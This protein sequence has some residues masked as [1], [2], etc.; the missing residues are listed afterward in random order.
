VL[1]ALGLGA[2]AAAVY[3]AIVGNPQLG[4][5]KLAE[6]LDLD[7]SEIRRALDELAQLSLIRPSWEDPDALL[8]VSP[9]VSMAALLSQQERDLLLRQQELARA[10][11]EVLELIHFTDRRESQ[12]ASDLR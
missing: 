4:V 9:A 3:A 8:P 11:S 6:F 5:R 10:R 1:E 7:V 2:D 12:M